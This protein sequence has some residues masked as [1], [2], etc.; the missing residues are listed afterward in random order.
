MD[1]LD[2]R[3]YLRPGD[4][5]AVGQGAGE[6]V[7]LVRALRSAAESIPDLTVFAGISLSGL[8]DADLA[9][10]VRLVSYAAMGTLR[11]VAAAGLLDVIP[12]A[13]ADLPDLM[14]ALRPDV[15]L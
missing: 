9:R 12:C 3:R 15:V 7:E 5:I 11:D 6:P 1:Q 10:H 8:I 2:L 13:Y 4:V 14:S